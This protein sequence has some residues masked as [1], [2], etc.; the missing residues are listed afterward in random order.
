V[1]LLFHLR[2]LRANQYFRKFQRSIYRINADLIAGS[3]SVLMWI[4]LSM[5]ILLKVVSFDK[6]PEEIFQLK[7]YRILIPRYRSAN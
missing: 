2:I 6:F 5:Q 4:T 3:K 1:V 7:L